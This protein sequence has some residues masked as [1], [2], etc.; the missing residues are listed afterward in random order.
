MRFLVHSAMFAFVMLVVGT[1][2]SSAGAR[3][4]AGVTAVKGASV[5][6]GNPVPANKVFIKNGEGTKGHWCKY[7]KGDQIQ[8]PD[9]AVGETAYCAEPSGCH[10]GPWRNIIAK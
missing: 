4:A 8:P 3:F 9:C 1:S 10:C 5:G 7:A 6:V 2:Y